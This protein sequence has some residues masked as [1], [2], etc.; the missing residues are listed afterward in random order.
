MSINTGLLHSPAIDTLEKAGALT[1]A[2]DCI[3]LPWRSPEVDSGEKRGDRG[4]FES[5]SFV[6]ALLKLG[7]FVQIKE[8]Q[9]AKYRVHMVESN[10]AA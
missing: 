9:K 3:S 2:V 7:G 4:V 8:H 1:N 10:P 6:S 5:N